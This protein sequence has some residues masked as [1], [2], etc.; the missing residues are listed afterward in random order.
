MGPVKKEDLL[1]FIWKMRL[2]NQ[3]NLRTTDGETITILKPGHQNTNAGPDF[4]DAR[5]KIGEAVWAGTVEVHINS[6]QWFEHRHDKD[7]AYS[8]VILHVVYEH[9]IT[10]FHIPTLALK[11]YIDPR[12]FE[13]YQRMM[14]T[15]DWIPCQRNLEQIQL[16]KL[17]GWLEFL[18]VERIEN[19]SQRL[20]STLNSNTNNW[21]QTAWQLLARSMG[22]PV[23]AEPMEQ[24]AMRV[25]IKFIRKI[26]GDRKTIEALLLGAGGFLKGPF[27]EIGP[28]QLQSIYKHQKTKHNIDE[29]EPQIWKFGRMRPAHFPTLRIS[30]LADIVSR[31]PS[32]MSLFLNSSMKSL[33]KSLSGEAASYWSEHY[34]FKQSAKNKHL[35]TGVGMTESII[36]NSVVPLVLLFGKMMD[37]DDKISH[38]IDLLSS[39]PS[40]K[41]SI[42][43]KW[44]KLNINANNAAESQALIQLYKDYCNN[45]RCLSCRIGFSVLNKICYI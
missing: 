40:E 18:A 15:A 14:E 7:D 19:K 23:N 34:H 1:Q 8:T 4:S 13:Q 30:Q 37:E 43:R 28:N 3:N 5:I 31:A 39:L 25:P 26:G 11:E 22:N 35:K 27:N 20:L 2:F 6:K 33:Q 17:P 16:E 12:Y 41:N 21:E 45:R 38:A 10:N 24:L 29:L 32:L 36:I 44:R 42:I 9:D